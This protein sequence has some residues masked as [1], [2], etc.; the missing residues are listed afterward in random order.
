MDFGRGRLSIKV[1]NTGEVAHSMAELVP[2]AID[3]LR[4]G[5]EADRELERADL[6]EDSLLRMPPGATP[7][8]QRDNVALGGDRL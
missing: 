3:H 1:L 5:M 4:D 7:A 2:M 8:I 6:R